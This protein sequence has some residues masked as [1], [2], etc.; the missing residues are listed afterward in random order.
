MDDGVI[1]YRCHWNEQHSLKDS[2]LA[3]IIYWR[4]KAFAKAYIGVYDNGIGFGNISRRED[5]GFIISGSATGNIIKTTFDHYAFVDKW[6]IKENQL[7]C[8]GAVQASSESL[9]HAVIYDTL[10]EIKCILHI[11]DAKLWQKYYSILPSTAKEIEYGTP[12]M[13]NAIQEL[14]LKSNLSAG[15]FLMKGHEEGLISF[16][17]NFEQVFENFEKLEAN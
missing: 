8:K 13:A 14:I 10:A 6:N 16:G 3:S 7:W 15:V 4:D 11:H 5:A 12:E 9:S 1:K 17:I 2:N